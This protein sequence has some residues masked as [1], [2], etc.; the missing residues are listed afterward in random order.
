[1]YPYLLTGWT[2]PSARRPTNRTTN[3]PLILHEGRA[4]VD[5]TTDD[6]DVTDADKSGRGKSEQDNKMPSE[7]KQA[8]ASWCS[9]RSSS[10]HAVGTPLFRKRKFSGDAH[11]RN[12][13]QTLA[14][15]ADSTGTLYQVA[16]LPRP[17]AARTASVRLGL[18]CSRT[19]TLVVLGNETL[20]C[21]GKFFSA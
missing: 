10:Q 16:V 9:R 8:G 13:F 15:R 5:A 12:V 20:W 19:H 11:F 7:V 1:M 3:Q 17:P 14:Y 21:R 6:A 2:S 4:E 18:G